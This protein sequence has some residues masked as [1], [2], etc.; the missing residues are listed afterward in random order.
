MR[1]DIWSDLVCP[2]CYV[3]KRRF[4]RALAAFAHADGVEVIHRSFQL[5]PS[6]PVGQTMPRRD[7]LMSKYGLTDAQV[8]AMDAKME[9]TAAH[10]GLDYHLAGGSTGNTF[11]VHRLLHLAHARGVQDAAIERFY[12]AYFT[13]QRSLFDRASL[14]ALSVEAGLDEA[15]VRAVLEGDAYGDAVVADGEEARA[16]G[17][18]GV[19][20]FVIDGRY[21]ISGAQPAEVFADA[22]ERAWSESHPASSS[23]AE[24]SGNAGDSGVCTDDG[25]EA[26]LQASTTP[27]DGRL[28]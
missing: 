8:Q 23:D 18:N 6:A 24:Q 17:A 16:S 28:A 25:C 14:L 22:L 9:R 2:W 1:I 19:P 7:V 15:E 20:F 10:E 21:G 12:R 5:N 26:G 3:G 13:E 11:D 4:E 27:A